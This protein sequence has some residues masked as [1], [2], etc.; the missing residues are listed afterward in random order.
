MNCKLNLIWITLAI[1]GLSGC[2]TMSGDECAM[3]DWQAV[4]YED[5][6]RGYT[7]DRIGQYRKACAKHGVTP[8]L[9]SY[10]QGREQ[11]LVEYCQPGRGFN[12]GS[13]G[14]RYHGVCRADLEPGFLEAYNAGYHLYT[15]HSNVNRANSA[16]HAK[17]GELNRI[18]ET[19]HETE[20]ALISLDTSIEDR[21][22][23]LADLK[24]LSER[25][26]QLEAEIQILYEDRAHYQAE[27]E[28]YQVRVADFGY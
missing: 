19:V 25:T 22:I 8:D 10:Q 20:I 9:S 5:G 13:S 26:G 1:V 23:L 21:I 27:L 12:V 6:V 15:L 17:E 3:S 24:D 16:I 14:N 4:G 11:G 7:G 2:A 28:N 18:E